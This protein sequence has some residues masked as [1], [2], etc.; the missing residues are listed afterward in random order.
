MGYWEFRLGLLINLVI[1]N[2]LFTIE[3]Q[4]SGTTEFYW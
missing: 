1:A 2:I 3:I 4:S